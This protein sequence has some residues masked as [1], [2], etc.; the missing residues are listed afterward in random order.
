MAWATAL[1]SAAL[2]MAPITMTWGAN[3]SFNILAL[4]ALPLSATTCFYLVH[5]IT[6]RFFPSLLSGYIF[7]FSSY[8]LAQ[9]M[10]HAN[11][12]LTFLLPLAILL[13]IA[14]T[15]QSISRAWFTSLMVPIVAI[16]FGLSKEILATFS[17]FSIVSIVAFYIFSDKE[18][19]SHLISTSY[20]TL[21]SLI[22][23]IFLLS[24][25]IYYLAT[26]LRRLPAVIHSPT[27]YSSD[28]LNY[29]IPTPVTRL[30]RYIFSNIAHRFTG[31]YGEQDAYMGVPLLLMAFAYLLKSWRHRLTKAIYIILAVLILCS[32]GPYLHV[33]GINTQIP[34]PW[35]FGAHMPLIKSALPARFPLYVSL[36]MAVIVG[37]WLSQHTHKSVATIKYAATFIAILFIVPNPGM[38]SWKHIYVPTLFK[39]SV[40]S[41]YIPANTNILY[42]PY[43]E[44]GRSGYYQ[45]ASGMA[46]TQ[47]GGYVGFT[48]V[49]FSKSQVVQSLY[50]GRVGKGF[51]SQLEAFC[52]ENHIE[53]IIYRPATDKTLVSAIAALQW[54][55]LKVGRSTL[56]SVPPATPSTPF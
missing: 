37:L 52:H 51:D 50:S 29:I 45:Y 31:N 33:N 3:A 19:R 6:K 48:P 25:Y 36:V 1:P 10:Y 24:P 16:Q 53:S 41:K 11:L 18:Q 46:F 20:D 22:I 47:S 9:L 17:V 4:L 39:K 54:P 13:F 26:G 15:Q 14:R 12:Y 42:L 43:G 49:S 27:Y 5:R 28:L 23:S 7:G 40:I 44:L 21:A 30:G 38:Y 35:S 34:L 2:I 32:F 56:V 8:E 55:S